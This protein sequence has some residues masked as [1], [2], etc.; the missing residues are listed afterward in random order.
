MGQRDGKVKEVQGRWTNKQRKRRRRRRRRNME[1]VRESR[2]E[3]CS[4]KQTGRGCRVHPRARG[5]RAGW[6]EGCT[7]TRR[8]RWCVVSQSDRGDSLGAWEKLVTTPVSLTQRRRQPSRG[9]RKTGL[10]GWTQGEIPQGSKHL[11]GM[12]GYTPQELGTP[13]PGASP[14][15][16]QLLQDARYQCH[17]WRGYPYTIPPTTIVSWISWIRLK[18][19]RGPS[20]R[21][22]L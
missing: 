2:G 3:K 17:T 1:K 21:R 22:G 18:S 20:W 14:T 5:G 16:T 11:M 6:C 8:R 4:T 15:G 12:S 13:M 7:G 19:G 9:H 10:V